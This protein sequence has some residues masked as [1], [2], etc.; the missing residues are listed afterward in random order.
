MTASVGGKFDDF[1]KTYNL[2]S[3]EVVYSEQEA[4]DKGLEIDHDDTHACLGTKSFALL[5]HG[6]GQKGSR[7]AKVHNELI[8]SMAV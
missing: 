7:Q 8:R 5:I 4:K 3:A 6:N 1:I 2:K